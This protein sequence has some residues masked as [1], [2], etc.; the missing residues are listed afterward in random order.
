MDYSLKEK[1]TCRM[2]VVTTVP[3]KFNVPSTFFLREVKLIAIVI[4]NFPDSPIKVIIKLLSL[5]YEF[6]EGLRKA[7]RKWPY[8]VPLS[9]KMEKGH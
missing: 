5:V 4:L 1:D 7:G 6:C 8:S 9:P 3:E 2:R